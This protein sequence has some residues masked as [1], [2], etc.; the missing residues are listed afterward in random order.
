MR[1]LKGNIFQTIKVLR[2]AINVNYKKTCNFLNFV[3]LI[4]L[5]EVWLVTCPRAT[6]QGRIKC[7]CHVTIPKIF[8]NST[9]QSLSHGKLPKFFVD[10]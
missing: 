1:D 2:Q 3:D 8:P 7:R 10:L 5:A 4:E 9:Q 6:Q